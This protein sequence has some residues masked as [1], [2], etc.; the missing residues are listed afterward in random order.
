MKKLSK[1]FL[2]LGLVLVVVFI[3][4]FA[5]VP[6]NAAGSSHSNN[7]DSILFGPIQDDE[8]GCGVFMILNLIV[9]ILSFG[10]GIAGVIG[11]TIVGIQYLTA[12]G[13]EQQVAKAKRRMFEIVI[14]IVSYAAI[15]G[16][17]NWALPGGSFNTSKQCKSISQEEL[18][19]SQSGTNTGN[20]QG[21][22]GESTSQNSTN[23]S[24]TI[25]R[26]ML[27][28]ASEYAK[29][30][31]QNNIKY[32]LSKQSNTWSKV[33]KNG[34]LNCAHYVSI[35]GQKV[36]I[37]KKGKTFWIGQGAIHGKGNLVTSKVKTM[38][39][40]N[41]T[42]E[43]LYKHKLLLPGDIVGSQS[44]TPHTMIFKEYKNKKYY[45]YSV[46]SVYGGV[47]AKTHSFKASQIS[48]KQ[49]SKN[50]KIGVIIHPK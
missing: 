36:G 47:S 37:V 20:S 15:W 14:G 27:Q 45:F 4:V 39:N 40:V 42:V 29:L 5:I 26:N 3:S 11:I 8:E 35:I 34:C 30:L 50:Y 6:V 46:N 43:Y 41:K 38:T 13:N 2:I 24:A 44:G 19:Q 49:Y 16:I 22:S 1:Q 23:G 48:N 7:V 12:K 21:S 10:V 33:L 18:E 25:G 17:L 31:D 28:V 9:D 32:C